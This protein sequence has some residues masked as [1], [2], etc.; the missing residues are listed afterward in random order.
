MS[1]IPAYAPP[2]SAHPDDRAVDA[3]A[4]AM[5][6]KLAEARAKGRGGWDDPNRCEV[7]Y[8]ADLLIEQ[9]TRRDADPIDIANLAMFVHARAGGVEALHAAIA[10]SVG[11]LRDDD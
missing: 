10:Q 8:L 4:A 9:V 11:L 2:P 7:R 6:A 3:F 5:K 1:D